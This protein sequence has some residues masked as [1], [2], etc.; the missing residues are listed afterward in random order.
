MR[1]FPRN[2][3]VFLRHPSCFCGVSP[4]GAQIRFGEGA[5]EID[6]GRERMRESALRLD[7]RP[8]SPG[9]RIAE[10]VTRVRHGVAFEARDQKLRAKARR[11]IRKMPVY[12]I[13]VSCD[14][15]HWSTTGDLVVCGSS[16]ARPVP[17]FEER[18]IT[19]IRKTPNNPVIVSSASRLGAHGS[20][21]HNGAMG[22]FMLILAAAP[23]LGR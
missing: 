8:D 17:P 13:R 11:A 12:D 7:D 23:G 15:H 5:T 2:W 22:L 10:A 4:T 16:D 1:R 18:N 21:G 14:R 20:R 6:L 3:N 19:M 9:W